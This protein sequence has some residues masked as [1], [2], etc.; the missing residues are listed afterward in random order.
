VIVNGSV[1]ITDSVFTGDRSGVTLRKTV[2]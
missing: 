1:T 2:Y